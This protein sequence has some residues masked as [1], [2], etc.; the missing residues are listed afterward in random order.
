MG[1]KNKFKK[2]YTRYYL[3]PDLCHDVKKK[4]LKL[5]KDPVFNPRKIVS[6]ISDDHN[7]K[8][9]TLRSWIKKWDK[10]MSWIFYDEQEQNLMDYIEDNYI[11]P[12]GYF[13]NSQ[14]QNLAFE[15]YDNIYREN[16]KPPNFVCINNFISKFKKNI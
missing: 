7:I 5:K 16:K 3:Q 6:T 10:E 9:T 2:S 11:E 13:S 8:T 12:K 4:Y 15:T 1:R 14:F